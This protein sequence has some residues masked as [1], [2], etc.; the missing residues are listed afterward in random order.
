MKVSSLHSSPN[1]FVLTLVHI[2]KYLVF[3]MKKFLNTNFSVLFLYQILQPCATTLKT[4]GET[5]NYSHHKINIS[6]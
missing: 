6:K 4:V 5:V 1:I 2:P 3:K